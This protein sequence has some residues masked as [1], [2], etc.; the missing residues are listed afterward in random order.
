M[1]G[2]QHQPEAIVI[3][4]RVVPWV[5]MCQAPDAQS[6]DQACSIDDGFRAVG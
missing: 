1:P 5:F 4:R 2:A 6:P 3:C